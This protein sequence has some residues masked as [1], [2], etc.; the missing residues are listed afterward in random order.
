MILYF[1]GTGNSAFAAR[2]IADTLGDEAVNLLEKLRAGDHSPMTS[3][4]PWVIAA[5][6]YAWQMP[7]VVRDWLRETEL[8][9]SRDIYFAITCGGHI[10]AAGAH[11]RKLCDEKGLHYMGCAE[12]VMPENYIAMFDAPAEQEAVQIVKAALPQIDRVSA[13]IAA[14]EPIPEKFT[15]VQRFMSSAVNRGFYFG[16]ITDKKFA[17]SDACIGC[18]LCEKLCPLCNITLRDGKPVWNGN[19]THCMSC[20]CRCP[21]SAIEYG[22]TSVGKP[23]YQCPKI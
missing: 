3:E 23:R 22:R 12:I 2:R 18:G 9:G 15:V 13:L 10:A 16:A 20:I 14:G 17:A 4:R 1:S 11:A 8:Q 19:C 7:H 21:Q 6:V 5:P